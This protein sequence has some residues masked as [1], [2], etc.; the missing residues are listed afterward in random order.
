MSSTAKS[1]QDI[2]DDHKVCP[3]C[4]LEI[5]KN[6]MGS[7]KGSKK[8]KVYQDR[9][10][11]DERGLV[12]APN[13]QSIREFLEEND[14]PLETMRY[15]YNGN[16]TPQYGYKDTVQSREYT[17]QDG[18]KEA[19]KYVLPSPRENGVPVDIEER[20]DGLW[21]CSS[22]SEKFG[23]KLLFVDVDTD[24]DVSRRRVAYVNTDNTIAFTTDG[25]RVGELYTA[26]EAEENLDID[27]EEII[28]RII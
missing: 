16:Q 2:E 27:S 15:K 21:V 9:N 10:E 4:G 19:K 20:I 22:G 7:H 5:H 3:K 17:T 25:D 1:D 8:C 13:R 23:D 28:S 18:I 12:P 26:E 24:E 6:G 11:I 14:Y